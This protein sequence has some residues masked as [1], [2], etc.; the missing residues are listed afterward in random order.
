MDI[1]YKN[2][3]N[4]MI[5]CSEFDFGILRAIRDLMCL[6]FFFKGYNSEGEI[7]LLFMNFLFLK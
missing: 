1:Y 5:L 3:L 2:M 6:L 4:Y 7:I